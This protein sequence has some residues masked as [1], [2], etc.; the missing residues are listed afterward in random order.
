MVRHLKGA[1]GRGP[2]RGQDASCT[3]PAQITRVQDTC[4]TLPFDENVAITAYELRQWSRGLR[5]FAAA[6]VG[7]QRLDSH[8]DA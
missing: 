3:R 1:G 2:F 8:G 7:L 5:G 4:A 6:I